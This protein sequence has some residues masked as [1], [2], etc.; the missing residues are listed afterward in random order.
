MERIEEK[1]LLDI[2]IEQLL[3]VFSVNK[4]VVI[5]PMGNLVYFEGFMNEIP[6][7]FNNIVVREIQTCIRRME[8]ESAVNNYYTEIFL[9]VDKDTLLE[10]RK[11]NM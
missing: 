5:K 7:K 1:K 6:N 10:D 3:L 2:T 4:P 8:V 11:D 9:Y